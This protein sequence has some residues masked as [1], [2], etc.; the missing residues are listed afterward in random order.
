MK[1][2]LLSLLYWSCLQISAS[3]PVEDKPGFTPWKR[4][5]EPLDAEK[6][7]GKLGIFKKSKFDLPDPTCREKMK[8]DEGCWEMDQFT[9]AVSSQIHGN[10]TDGTDFY[11]K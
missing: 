2:F 4:T 3:L 6:F 9:V 7:S 5:I 8:P 1:Q 10:F 11:R